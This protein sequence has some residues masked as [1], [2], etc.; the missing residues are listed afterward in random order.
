[1]SLPRVEWHDAFFWV[2]EAC[3]RDNYGRYELLDLAAYLRRKPERAELFA[4]YDP[5][6]RACFLWAEDVVTCKHCDAQFERL[7]P[8]AEEGSDA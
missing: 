7:V 3:G 6:P 5:G 8:E 1:M 2:C 4:D